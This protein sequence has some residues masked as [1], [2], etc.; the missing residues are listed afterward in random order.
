MK[1][2]NLRVCSFLMMNIE[3]NKYMQ[4]LGTPVR[5]ICSGFIHHLHQRHLH[6]TCIHLCSTIIYLERKCIRILLELIPHFLGHQVVAGKGFSEATHCHMIS[7]RISTLQ[8]FRKSSYP[9]NIYL[10]INSKQLNV[11]R[12]ENQNATKE[13]MKIYL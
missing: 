4:H 10:Y 1:R 2:E 12:I 6:R 9:D 13:L 7:C 3:Y 11:Y 8:S 5:N